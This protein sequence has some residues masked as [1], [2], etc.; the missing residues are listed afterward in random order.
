[1]RQASHYAA[2]ICLHFAEMAALFGGAALRTNAASFF[3]SAGSHD[4]AICIEP[5]NAL[6]R[7]LKTHLL[8]KAA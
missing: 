3:I 7:H 1:M 2:A 6:V 8:N 5:I 4:A